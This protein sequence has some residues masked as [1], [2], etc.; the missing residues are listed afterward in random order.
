MSDLGIVSY[1]LGLEVKQ[2][3]TGLQISQK[4]YVTDLLKEYNILHCKPANVPLLPSAQQQLYEDAEGVD[5]TMYR[6]L[7]GKLIHV[8]QSRP[9]IVF[10]ISLLSRF[11]HKPTKIHQGAAKDVLR[12]LAGTIQFGILYQRVDTYDAQGFSDSDWGSNPVDR[13]S[14]TG[15]VFNIGSGVVT[16]L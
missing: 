12:Y 15:V 6:K 1:F 13:K 8:T 3:E 11:M 14:T 16:W 4:K 5:V 10:V 9:D 2:T 7:F